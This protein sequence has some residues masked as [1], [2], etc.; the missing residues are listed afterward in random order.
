MCGLGAL[1]GIPS[2]FVSVAGYAIIFW[3]VAA[4]VECFGR[5]LDRIRAVAIAFVSVPTFFIVAAVHIDSDL[6]R[7]LYV[8][9]GLLPIALGLIT[10]APLLFRRLR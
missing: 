6:D 9:N 7:F 1:V 2:L 3:V 4:V 5:L 8:L 10:L